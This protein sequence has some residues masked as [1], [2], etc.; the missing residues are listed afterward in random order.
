MTHPT[1]PTA[2][3]V[4]RDGPR[5]WHWIA[6]ESFD[7]AVH[8]LVE[9]EAPAPIDNGPEEAPAQEGGPAPVSAPKRP[10]RKVTK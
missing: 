7:P 3:K 1:N 5:G 10:R 9:G 4:K 2:L 8:E 6:A